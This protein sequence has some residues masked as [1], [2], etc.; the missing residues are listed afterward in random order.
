MFTYKNNII[1]RIMKIMF[2]TK[3]NH[4]IIVFLYKNKEIHFFYE[5]EVKI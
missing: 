2:V 1:F 4:S 5:H 3:I